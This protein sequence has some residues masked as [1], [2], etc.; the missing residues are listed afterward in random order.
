MPEISRFLLRVEKA[1]YVNGHNIRVSF[2]DGRCGVADLQELVQEDARQI[3]AELGDIDKFKDFRV[4]FDTV[5]W[6][7]GF[8]LAP[9]YLYFLAFRKAPELR[10]KFEEWGYLPAP[11]L[12]RADG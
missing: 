1:E 7:N 10:S 4:H 5:C 11:L 2:N 8:D 12:T 9:E 6:A 3:V